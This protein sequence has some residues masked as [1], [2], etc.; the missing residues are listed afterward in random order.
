M[1]IS[2]PQDSTINTPNGSLNFKWHSDFGSLTEKEF[3]KAQ[4]FVD[5]EVIRQMIPYTPMDTG[6]L[7]KS[8]TVGTVIGSGKVV[9]LGPYAR[10]LYYGVVY[11]P[12]IPL[13]KN[14]ELVGFYSPPRKYPTGR[15][16][17]YST[18]KH[19]LAGKMWFERMKKD[20]KDVILNGT[21]KILG[22][23]V[24]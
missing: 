24:K 16:L 19:P 4:R 12:N 21:A 20:K 7:F 1:I 2:Q 18:A 8:T 10:Y 14:G 11:G 6:F 17:Q 9:Q 22:G 15:E 23:N 5:N 3:Q 13:Y